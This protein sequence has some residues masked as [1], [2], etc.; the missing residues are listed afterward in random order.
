MPDS[1]GR[2]GALFAAAFVIVLLAVLI[3]LST[4]DTIIAG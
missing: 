1:P 2:A 3:V 4:Q